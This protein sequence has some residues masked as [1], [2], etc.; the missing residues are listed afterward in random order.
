MPVRWAS[1]TEVFNGSRGQG[2]GRRMGEGGVLQT[3]GPCSSSVIVTTSRSS[4][5]LKIVSRS[6][7]KCSHTLHI[8]YQKFSQCCL[9]NSS[10][11]CLT[12]NRPLFSFRRKSSS[13]S[14]FHA[15]LFHAMDDVMLLDMCLQVLSQAPQYL[16]FSET[17][18][19]SDGCFAHQ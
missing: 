18:T 1:I 6:T 5:Q 7:Q 10:N 12:D 11:V 4:V 8:T 2:S 15:S 9:W 3:T 16:R 14:S 13:A 17:Q 19:T